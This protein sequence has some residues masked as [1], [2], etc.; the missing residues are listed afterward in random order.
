MGGNPVLI[1]FFSI[2]PTEFHVRVHFFT[3]ILLRRADPNWCLIVQKRCD[4]AGAHNTA[5]CHAGEGDQSLHA[6]EKRR[7]AR[8]ELAT[9]AEHWASSAFC[10]KAQLRSKAQLCVVFQKLGRRIADCVK[11]DKIWKTF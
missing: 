11:N 3:L 6:D 9:P 8:G 7:V 1:R 4:A 5:P 2:V 10:Q